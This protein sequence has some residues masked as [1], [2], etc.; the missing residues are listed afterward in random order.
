MPAG[1]KGKRPAS[2]ALKSSRTIP[3]SQFY[4][5]VCIR[6]PTERDVLHDN[7]ALHGMKE[8]CD[9]PGDGSCFFHAVLDQ[10]N[11]L[12]ISTELPE[13][14]SDPNPRARARARA[15]QLRQAALAYFENLVSNDVLRL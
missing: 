13:L 6:R 14:S 1:R 9:V 7:L 12:G 4:K 8:R 5:R 2:S 3:I 15:M 11:R 10:Y